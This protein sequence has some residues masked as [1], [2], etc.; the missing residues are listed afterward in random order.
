M[1]HQGFHSCY[2]AN[3]FNDKLLS[4]LEHILYRCANEQKDAGSEKP[5][6]VYVTGCA[7]AQGRGDERRRGPGGAPVSLL[8]WCT[9]APHVPQPVPPPD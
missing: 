4:R 9:T 8:P 2:T 5:V 1:V 3:G 6:N 7:A